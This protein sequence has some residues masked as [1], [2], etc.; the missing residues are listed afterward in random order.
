MFKLFTS[1]FFTNVF[2]EEQITT[3]KKNSTTA[4]KF[5]LSILF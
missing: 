3:N 1:L 2:Q 5:D 4:A